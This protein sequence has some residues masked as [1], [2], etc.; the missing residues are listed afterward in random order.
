MAARSADAN[1]LAGLGQVV[2]RADQCVAQ[3]GILPDQGELQLAPPRL[4]QG[5][6]GAGR[7]L[8][9]PRG[10]VGR[11]QAQRGANGARLR[12]GVGFR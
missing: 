9:P 10:Q 12:G 7:P 6:A 1:P 5:R 2:Q 11:I 3:P 4:P 8:G